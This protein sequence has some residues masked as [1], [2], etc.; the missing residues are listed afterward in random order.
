MLEPT[1][2]P[3]RL[4]RPR[5]AITFAHARWDAPTIKT[6]CVTVRDCPNMHAPWPGE[7]DLSGGTVRINSMRHFDAIVAECASAG[8]P[9]DYRRDVFVH[10]RAMLAFVPPE[11][12]LV[13]ILRDYGS[14]LYLCTTDRIDAKN[15]AWDAPHFCASSFGANRCRFYTWDGERLREHRSAETCADAARELAN[16]YGKGFSICRLPPVTTRDWRLH[17][18]VPWR[19]E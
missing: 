5:T 14:C 16:A 10:D 15:F 9:T 8:W 1:D 17:K 13:W 4:T 12:P 11:V 6:A 3:K 7:Q 19:C 18:D 2:I